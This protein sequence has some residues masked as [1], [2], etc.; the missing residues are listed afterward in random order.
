MGCKW[1]NIKEKK[2]V[3]DVNNSCVYV[4]FGI[5]IYVVVKLGDFDFYVN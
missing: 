1:V 2:V 4:K 3:K 5:E